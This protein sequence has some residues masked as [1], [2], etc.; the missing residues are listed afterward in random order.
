MDSPGATHK[1]FVGAAGQFVL[2]DYKRRPNMDK[3]GGEAS[4]SLLVHEYGRV[5]DEIVFETIH[6]GLGD[7]DA[8]KRG[9]L[10]FLGEPLPSLAS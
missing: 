7:F 5:N 10:A 4:R 1:T 3:K 6:Q 2:T 8:F 9:I